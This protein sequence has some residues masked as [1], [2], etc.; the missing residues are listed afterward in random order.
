MTGMLANEAYIK[1]YGIEKADEWS[2]ACIQQAE[3]FLLAGVVLQRKQWEIAARCRECDLPNGPKQ[4]MVGG[5]RGSS[6]SHGILAQIFCD[7]CQR[8]K[9]LKFHEI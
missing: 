6:K 5:G 7:D 2:S 1:V 8:I 4:I 9:G 3:N